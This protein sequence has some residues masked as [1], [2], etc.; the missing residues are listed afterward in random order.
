MG[1]MKTTADEP[2]SVWLSRFDEALL[3][4][5][6]LSRSNF[7]SDDDRRPYCEAQVGE[8]DHE[9][10]CSHH[11]KDGSRYCGTHQRHRRPVQL[12]GAER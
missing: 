10:L 2:L 4:M 1:D 7:I 11:A 9:R 6:R 8:P 3:R 12:F 5:E